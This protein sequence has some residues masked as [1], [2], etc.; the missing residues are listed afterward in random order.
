MTLNSLKYHVDLTLV[1]PLLGTT[2]LDTSVAEE[3]TAADRSAERSR[4]SLPDELLDEELETIA[5][6]EGPRGLTGFHR[7]NGD[8]DG[9]PLLYDYIIKGFFKDACGMLRRVPTTLSSKVTAYKK[10]VDGLIFVRPRRIVLHLPDGEGPELEI[11]ERPLRAST[12]RGERVTIAR[13]EVVPA[14]TTLAFDLLVMGAGK[15]GRLNIEELLR[16]WLDYGQLR[17]LGQWRNASWGTFTYEMTA[18]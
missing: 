12:A 11:M 16:E 18:G 1:E 9:D 14:G 10:T 7:V 17:G 5:P 13:S 3:F 8:S 2:P 6:V 15:I 4:R